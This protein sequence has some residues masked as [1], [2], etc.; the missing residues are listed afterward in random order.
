[1]TSLFTAEI[2]D[3]VVTSRKVNAIHLLQIHERNR[4][5]V[6]DALEAMICDMCGHGG[7][8][9]GTIGMSQSFSMWTS[10]SSTFFQSFIFRKTLRKEMYS[11]YRM[12]K[13][14][15]QRSLDYLGN[16]F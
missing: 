14:I 11:S 8:F 9:V 13:F 5:K 12:T 6:H 2:D 15:T 1:M 3:E 4:K 7:K 10:K 16:Y